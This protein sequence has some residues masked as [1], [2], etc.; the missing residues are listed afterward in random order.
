MAAFVDGETTVGEAREGDFE[1]AIE[2]VTGLSLSTIR[3]K[4]RDANGNTKLRNLFRQWPERVDEVASWTAN[5]A[6][7]CEVIPEIAAITALGP[8]V[9][10]RRLEEAHGKTL[11]QNVFSAE[12]LFD[13]EDGEGGEATDDADSHRSDG[14]SRRSAPRR[15]APASEVVT[16]HS[17]IETAAN[18]AVA[19]VEVAPRSTMFRRY[20]LRRAR[21]ARSSREPAAHQ[22]EAL[23][24]LHAW[25]RSRPASDRGGILA[26]PTGSGKTFTTVRF[27]C[28]EPLSDG[29]KVLWLAHTHHLLEQ[30]IDAFGAVEA[31]PGGALEV[32]R[33][34]EPRNQLD[35]RV[36]SATPGHFPVNTISSADDVVVATLQT[37][38]AAYNRGHEKL[39]SFLDSADGKLIVVFD[40]AHHAPAPSYCK[41]LER[42]REAYPQLYLLGLT[43]TPTFT[44]ERRQGWLKKLFPQD[45]LFTVSRSRLIAAGVLSKPHFENCR[46]EIAVELNEADYQRWLSSYGDLPED[47]V[48]Q[49]AENQQR[50]DVIADTYVEGRERYGKTIFFAD[51]WFQCDYLREALQKRGVRA[52]VV[53]SHVDTNLGSSDERNRRSKDENSRV[54]QQFRNG[55][56][57][58]II[59]V[60][61]LTEGTDVPSVKS[62]FLTRQTT[63]AILLTQMIGRALRGPLFGGTDDAHIVSFIDNWKQVINFADYEALPAGQADPDK[64]EYGKRPPLQLISIELVRRLARQ[65]YKGGGA[66]AP[67]VTLLPIG[68]Y[69]V[70]Y[71]T[72]A[73]QGDDVVWQRQLVMVFANE[74]GRYDAFIS[75]LAE[76]D[77]AAYAEETLSLNDVRAR[78]LGCQEKFFAASDDH[79][80]AELLVDLFHIARHMGQ[81]DGQAPVFFRFEERSGH[82]VDAIASDCIERDL[83]VRALDEAL[84][85]EYQRPDRFWRSLYSN[86]GLFYAQ[87][88]AA[89]RRILDAARHGA[90]PEHYSGTVTTPERVPFREP[91]EAVKELVFRRDVGRCCCCGSVKRLEVDH[92]V[93]AYLGGS[94]ELDQLQTLCRICNA[95]KAINELNFRVTRTPLDGPAALVALAPPRS[96]DAKEPENWLAY[97][98]R[99]INFFYRCA[100]VEVI[101]LGGTQAGCEVVLRPGI[102]ATWLEPHLP[103]L[104]AQVAEARGAEGLPSLGKLRATVVK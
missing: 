104:T 17:G 9:V 74:K 56:L 27:L 53:Y 40:E 42:L 95:E 22:H 61:M 19:I 59:N 39:T 78:L 20:D 85:A 18:T 13:N 21:A 98:Q 31:G 30:A 101:E 8:R 51:R 38:V 14:E 47:V 67:F 33:I 64:P 3:T 81:T 26:L 77:L 2:R 45:V 57:D 96:D 7:Q 52:D 72:R 103:N 93:P 6:L 63:S 92:I 4:L 79:P 41:L 87:Y 65:M 34:A 46:T 36:V 76:G 86:Y 73:G 68:W 70:E 66:Q 24:K 49:L 23:S 5:F 50:N 32:G 83:G 29:Y 35:V 82:D 102:D 44:D 43:A 28:Q 91:S 1:E 37:V 89:Q 62:V 94:S 25:Y 10:K 60:R 90:D 71:Q 55:E 48:T 100:A 84:L 16:Q 11:V 69:R 97:L 75:A 15:H 80:G 58:V 99:T 54:L 88:Q 12:W